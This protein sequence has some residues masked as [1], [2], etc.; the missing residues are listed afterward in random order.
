[1][2][3]LVGLITRMPRER[4]VPEL[5]RMVESLRHEPFY[6]TGTWNDERMGLYVGWTVHKASA[7]AT[8]SVRSERDGVV[9]VRSGEDVSGRSGLL[10][11]DDPSSLTGLNG[12]FHGVLADRQ[13]GRAVLFNDRYGM[14]RVYYHEG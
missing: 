14:H 8:P 3:G 11:G 5:L 10:I 2:P 6:E 9:M 7:A 1:M 12:R 13:R 4:A